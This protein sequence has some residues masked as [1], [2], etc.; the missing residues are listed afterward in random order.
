MQLTPYV[1]VRAR[2][3]TK[4]AGHDGGV[5]VV[6][7]AK[8][9]RATTTSKHRSLLHGQTY[10]KKKTLRTVALLKDRII[11]TKG[12]GVGV[13]APSGIFP[14]LGDINGVIPTLPTNEWP[15]DHALVWTAYRPYS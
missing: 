2:Q 3:V 6:P 14:D 10:D 1:R 11:G 13:V 7:D 4:C 12:G 9:P 8:D 15:S 5:A